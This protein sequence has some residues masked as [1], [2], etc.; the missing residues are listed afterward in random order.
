MM[1]DEI[2]RQF[3]LFVKPSRNKSCETKR[4]R[5]RVFL[6]CSLFCASANFGNPSSSGLQVG[7]PVVGQKVGKVV[8][9]RVKK[10]KRKEK[11]ALLSPLYHH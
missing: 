10:K 11:R 5:L 7:K 3:R 4:P 2:S 9:N 6:A 8:E 1:K